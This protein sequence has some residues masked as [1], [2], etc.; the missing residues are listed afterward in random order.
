MKNLF[1]KAVSSLRRFHNDEQ[2]IET[3]NAVMLL[4]IA[5]MV[6]VVLIS[7]GKTIIDWMKARIGEVTS[8]TTIG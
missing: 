3:I 4:A 6:V 8:K 7:Q 5:A 2:G 1:C